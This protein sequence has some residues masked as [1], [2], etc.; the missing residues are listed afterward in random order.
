MRPVDM[1][2]NEWPPEFS[3]AKLHQIRARAV[4]EMRARDEKR[5]NGRLSAAN[6]YKPYEF[7]P[8]VEGDDGTRGGRYVPQ[9][10]LVEIR[11]KG[12]ETRKL[13]VGRWAEFCSEPRNL[14]DWK[15]EHVASE[16]QIEINRMRDFAGTEAAPA[17]KATRRETVKT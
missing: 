12:Q 9:T 5:S 16:R 4:A 17:P 2:H 10:D 15:K 6:G 3:R 8:N 13:C 7:A 14:E 11:H 1:Q